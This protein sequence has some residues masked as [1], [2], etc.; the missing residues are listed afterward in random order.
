MPP[1][2]P[3]TLG[4]D[5][6]SPAAIPVRGWR[7]VLRR[8]WREAISDRLGLVAAGCAFYATVAEEYPN[9]LGMIAAGDDFAALAEAA[10]PRPESL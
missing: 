8:V 9:V 1:D 2:D 4:R 7:A 6:S 10:R 3:A 5:A